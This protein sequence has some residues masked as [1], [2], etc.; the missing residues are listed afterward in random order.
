MALKRVTGEVLTGLDPQKANFVIE[1]TKDFDPQRAAEASGLD[2]SDGY[3]LLKLENVERVINSVIQQ[4][5]EAADIDAQW[6]LM[7]AVDNHRIARQTGKIAASNAALNMIAKHY[8]VDAYAA[9]KVE[10]Q[11]DKEIAARLLR[12]R[13]RARGDDNDDSGTSFL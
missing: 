1:Y 5:L 4:R 8:A 10:V 12:G 13:Q 9:D 11:T 6:L 7:E 2:P 3:K